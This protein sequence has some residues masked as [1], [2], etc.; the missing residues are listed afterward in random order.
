MHKGILSLCTEMLFYEFGILPP[1]K[2]LK[3]RIVG[4]LHRNLRGF[5]C[6][7]GAIITFWN[8][9]M[10]P[11]RKDRIFYSVCEII[12]AKLRETV[13]VIKRDEF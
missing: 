8:D 2:T 1:P 10:T 11:F 6:E 4:V 7:I 9:L 3:N 12:E 13:I 5:P